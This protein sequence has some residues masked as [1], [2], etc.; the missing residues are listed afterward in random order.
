MNAA[1]YVQQIDICL[2]ALGIMAFTILQIIFIFQAVLIL[3]RPYL[4]A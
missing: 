1:A 2:S 3:S 4:M